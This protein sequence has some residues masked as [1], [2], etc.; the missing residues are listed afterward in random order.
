MTKILTTIAA[1]AICTA[2]F[3]GC[4]D[5]PA[6][7]PK[8]NQGGNQVQEGTD[9]PVTNNSGLE[10]PG[11]ADNG[12]KGGNNSGEQAQTAKITTAA[13]KGTRARK[14]R[15]ALQSKPHLIQKA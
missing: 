5:S 9:K 4:S 13:I 10:E 8:N 15:T 1:L 2:L 7:P 11:G 14:I 12:T 6:A 3:A